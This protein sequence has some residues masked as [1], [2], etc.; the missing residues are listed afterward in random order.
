MVY[1][2]R[3]N[4][5]RLEVLLGEKRTGL[6]VGRVVG[7][8]GKV[9]PGESHREAAVR[10]LGEEVGLVVEQNALIPIAQMSYPFLTRPHLSQRSRAFMVR[11]FSGTPM[12]SEELEP[13]WWS[14]DEIPFGRMWADAMLWLPQALNGHFQQATISIDDEDGVANVEWEEGH[15]N[16]TF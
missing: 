16:G 12:A 5:G 9:E 10:E 4:Q 1:P 2:L 8:G 14:I 7:P 3:D 6:G 15:T 11:D 13:A